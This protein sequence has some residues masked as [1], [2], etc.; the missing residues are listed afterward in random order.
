MDMS[1]SDKG[2][3]SRMPFRNS[4]VSIA[5]A[6]VLL[7]TASYAAEATATSGPGSGPATVGDQF[8]AGHVRPKVL[9]LWASDAYI[10]LRWHAWG[11]AKATARGKYSTHPGGDYR[12]IRGRVQLSR[13]RLCGGDRVYTHVRYTTFGHWHTGHFDESNCSVYA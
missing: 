11:S 4:C 13:I 9:H 3:P 1:R 7:G 12:Y 6:A 2:G 10:K 5:V 8:G